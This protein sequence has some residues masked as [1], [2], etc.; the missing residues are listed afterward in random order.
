MATVAKSCQDGHTTTNI[1][2]SFLYKANV[3]GD[4]EAKHVTPGKA[5]AL[6]R[7]AAECTYVTSPHSK[8]FSGLALT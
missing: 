3:T 4:K 6:D 2:H 5:L 7:G 8:S 1:L